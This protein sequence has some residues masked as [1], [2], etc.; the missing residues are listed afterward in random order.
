MHNYRVK[1]ALFGIFCLLSAIAHAETVY[2][3]DELKIGLHE[4]RTIDSPIIKLVPSGTPLSVIERDTD[5][6]HVQEAGGSKGWI[7]SKYVV[8]E[9]PG[10]SRITDLENSNKALQQE[11]A[12]P[13]TATAPANGSEAQKDLEQLLNSERL[14]AGDLQ[15]QLAALKAN[16]ADIDD[17]GILLADIETLKQ[18]NRQLISQL[19]SS[20]IAVEANSESLSEN[21]FSINSMKQMLVTLLIVFTIGIAGG[22]FILDFYN[23]RRHGGFRV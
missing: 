18:E 16:V 9:K 15:A 20:G 11:I 7:H 22:I 13:K 5:L 1:Y 2:V 4:D 12:Q 23:R 21:L 6:I 10:K 14:K 19:E 3:I 17:S 8:V